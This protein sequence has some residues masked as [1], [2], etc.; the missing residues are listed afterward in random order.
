[1]RQGIFVVPTLGLKDCVVA[2]SKCTEAT[3]SSELADMLVSYVAAQIGMY[4]Y[5]GKKCITGRE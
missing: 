5:L 1:M 4:L 2:I 3:S